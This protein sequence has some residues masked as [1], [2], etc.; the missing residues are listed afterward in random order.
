MEEQIDID[1]LI[2]AA[3]AAR[4]KAYTPYSDFKVGAALLLADGAVTE[5]CNIENASYGATVCAERVAILKARSENPEAQIRAIAVVTQSE[6]PS[7]PC[8]LCLQVMAE[9]CA[10]ETPIILANTGGKRLTYR[11][12][13]L[14]PHPF[15]KSLL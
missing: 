5:G 3:A 1:Q 9:F 14:L 11:F 15:T 7:P 10:P 12:D 6:S 13:E 4:E 2:A 8:A